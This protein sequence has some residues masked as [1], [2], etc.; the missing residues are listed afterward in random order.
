MTYKPVKLG[1]IVVALSRLAQE[2]KS[3]APLLPGVK[4]DSLSVKS[5]LSEIVFTKTSENKARAQKLYA[6]KN[7]AQADFLTVNMGS[8][9]YRCLCRWVW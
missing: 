9:R 2:M 4:L 1:S 6:D 5:N 3:E 8:V 7:F